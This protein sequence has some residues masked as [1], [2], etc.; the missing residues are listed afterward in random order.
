MTI[1]YLDDY[2]IMTENFSQEGAIL[3]SCNFFS[4]TSNYINRNIIELNLDE[5]KYFKE[6]TE[7]KEKGWFAK[8]IDAICGFFKWIWKQ[9]VKFVTWLLGLKD[10]FV[11]KVR[12]LKRK[13]EQVKDNI[14]TDFKN[15]TETHKKEDTKAVVD[16]FNL[17]KESD[18]NEFTT[19]LQD[20]INNNQKVLNSIEPLLKCK[21]AK[22]PNVLLSDNLTKI[23]SFSAKIKSLQGAERSST[24]MRE[25]F[26]FVIKKNDSD[27]L[28]KG[29]YLHKVIDSL[30]DSNVDKYYLEINNH[31]NCVFYDILSLS[32]I[33]L[34]TVDS[35][36]DDLIQKITKNENLTA[37]EQMV[38]N[39]RFKL[40]S[41]S[42]TLE[43][44][45]DF[46]IEE[47]I[48]NALG[49]FVKKF[50]FWNF[51]IKDEGENAIT[52]SD[53]KLV[54]LEHID[55]KMKSFDRIRTYSKDFNELFNHRKTELEKQKQ[56]GLSQRQLKDNLKV[57]KED[58]DK[59]EKRVSE[60]KF[61]KLVEI[62]DP[63]AKSDLNSGFTRLQNLTVLLMNMYNI[64]VTNYNFNIQLDKNICYI[65][66]KRTSEGGE[67]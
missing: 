42:L 63:K 5:L 67:K 48:S 62:A 6:E 8:V 41:D 51:V 22:H 9:V 31:I 64:M 35:L 38:V 59:I 36:G 30:T 56:D 47:S 15:W 12:A 50:L 45:T 19:I 16:F 39:D 10:V 1:N 20:R 40:I 49:L 14:E 28:T 7:K 55:K 53:M 32:S 25:L 58:S 27:D 65:A 46:Q 60:I 26:E 52:K 54:T 4:E 17:S 21:W 61:D 23:N 18:S 24:K 11:Y 66:N 44:K 57:F 43:K 33:M 3:R 29:G 37:N 13:Y 34:G 2:P